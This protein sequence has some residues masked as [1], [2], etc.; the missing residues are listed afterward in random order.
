ML[1][2]ST[3]STLGT[4]LL[5]F[6]GNVAVTFFMMTMVFIFMISAAISLTPKQRDR[7]N[8][9][10]PIMS[11][12]GQ[13]T[14][15][16]QRYL[17]VLTLINFLVGLIDAIFLIVLGV[18]FAILWGLLAWFLGYIPAVGF[19]LALIPPTLL[20]YVQYGPQTALIVFVGYVLING[21][22]QNL[23]QPKMMGSR[24]SI[25]PLVVFIT[26]LFWSWLLGGAGALLAVPL[27][28]VVISF[29]E[30]FDPTRWIAVLMRGGAQPRE[31]REQAISEARSF[32][33]R[34][35]D[36]AGRLGI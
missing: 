32:W 1:S 25:S 6:V 31:E 13:I 16:V 17:S 5:R 34:A 14:S 29:L 9:D 19:W 15:D 18:D 10:V 26:L 3:L 36:T 21:S 28:L 23:I 7:I 8:L 12:V 33:E 20:A 27:T 4:A 24:L 30:L 35:R 2:A 22:V 11:K